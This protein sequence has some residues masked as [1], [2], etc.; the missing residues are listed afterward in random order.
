M[1]TCSLWHFKY[2]ATKLATSQAFRR[3][4]S[5]VWQF[6]HWCREVVSRCRPVQ[7]P[8]PWPRGAGR[9]RAQAAEQGQR[10]VLITQNTDRL[11]Q[12]AGS[13]NVVEMY[14][15]LWDVVGATPAGFRDLGRP[16]WEDR[17]QR[18]VPALEGSS[19]PDAQ[20]ADVP[21]EELPHSEQ[22]QLLRP[23][24]VWFY[25]NLHK[26]VNDRI[27]DELDQADLLLIIGTSSVVSSSSQLAGYA[28]RQVAKRGVPVV[29]I[30]L[31]PTD[32]SRV[33]R[34]SIQGRAGELLPELLG[35]AGDPAVAA[36][37]E[38]QRS[39]SSAGGRN[40]R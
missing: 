16:P 26:A 13:S 8:Q 35:V 3:D 29:E 6:Y 5:L 21:V 27:D 11:H 37:V 1:P 34:M 17:R 4:P 2:G 30:N 9:V 38:E 31:E 22:G 28:L 20:P 39:S 14:G 36:A 23:G 25:E 15:S 40:S 24:V 18:L 33:C 12:A 19:D 10:F 32:N 7:Q